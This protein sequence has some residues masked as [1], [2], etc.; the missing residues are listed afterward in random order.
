MD[1][2]FTIPILLQG[3]EY[4]FD[5]RLVTVG[6][7]HKFIV[8]INGLEVMYEPDEERQY[9]AILDAN[10]NGS[11]TDSNRALIKAVGEKIQSIH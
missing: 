1:E 8:T 6:Y 2:A 11:V 10:D 5:A 3:K 9:R 4:S 7:T